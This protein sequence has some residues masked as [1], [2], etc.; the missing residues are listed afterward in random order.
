MPRPIEAIVHRDALAANLEVARAAA[1]GARV[2]AV[3]K[4]DAYGHGIANVFAALQRADGFALLDIGEAELLRRLG[5]RG[6]ILLLEGCFD[7]RDLE[8]CS[9]LHLWHVVH[10]SQQ[11]DRL[12]ALKTD[13]PQRVFLKMNS[14]MNRLGFAP[15][16]YRAAWLRLDALAQVEAIVLM[17]HLADADADDAAAVEPALAAF[18]AATHDLPG[19]RSVCNSA[20]T[21][22]F[23]ARLAAGGAAWVRPGILLY[24]SSPDASVHSADHW[25]LA[26][27]MTLR[28]RLIAIQELAAGA[29]I[30]Y[31]SSFT[32][33][34]PM[35]IGVVACGYAD[36]YPRLAPG[37]NERGTPILVDGV[38]TRTVGRVSMDMITIDLAPVPTATIGSEVVL[39]GRADNGTV[40]SIDDVAGA[41]GTVGY[42]LMCARAPRVPVH[43]QP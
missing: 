6:P 14:G 23:G 20:A 10:E 28:S 34:R 11:I 8:T 15:E 27:A 17:T 37:G 30:G 32:A 21:L 3:V 24:G 22:R 7:A 42:E 43:T 33:D 26:P 35:R 13:R 41:A 18:E 12:A 38:R 36:G 40:L 9:R 39:W 5:W 19:E 4:A 25:R 16:R 29:S 2:W 1:A 31:G